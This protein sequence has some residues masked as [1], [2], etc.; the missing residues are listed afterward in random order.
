[1]FDGSDGSL[2]GVVDFEDLIC[3]FDF[4]LWIFCLGMDVYMFYM[5]GIMGM[6]KGVM[7][8]Y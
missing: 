4:V 6:F 5:G 3:F 1:M 2:E 7:Y 8:E